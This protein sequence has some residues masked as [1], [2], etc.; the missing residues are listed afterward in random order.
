NNCSDEDVKSEQESEQWV[1]LLIVQPTLVIC[2]NLS[3][4]MSNHREI[5]I[6]SIFFCR[7]EHFMPICLL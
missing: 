6:L 3:D 2:P 4:S 7:A 5:L 1:I